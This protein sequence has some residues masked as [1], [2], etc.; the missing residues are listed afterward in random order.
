MVRDYMHEPIASG[1]TADRPIVRVVSQPRSTICPAVAC[2]SVQQR[3]QA[4][5][6][7]RQEDGEGI[8]VRHPGRRLERHFNRIEVDGRQIN[9]EDSSTASTAGVAEVVPDV[10]ACPADQSLDPQER[11]DIAFLA[12]FSYYG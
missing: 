8:R 4:D 9:L 7:L 3:R 12:P 1:L 10:G 6:R 5:P 2:S 11:Y